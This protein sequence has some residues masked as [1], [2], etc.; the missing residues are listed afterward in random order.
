MN[1][2]NEGKCGPMISVYNEARIIINMFLK[3]WSPFKKKGHWCQFLRK[4][5]FLHV[6]IIDVYVNRKIEEDQC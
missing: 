6:L 3:Q 1:E 5:R 2:K 4:G